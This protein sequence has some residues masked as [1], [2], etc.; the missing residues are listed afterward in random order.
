MHSTDYLIA[1]ATHNLAAPNCTINALKVQRC[2]LLT[3][4]SPS[5]AP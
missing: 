2:D 1:A 4:T 3:A 5:S